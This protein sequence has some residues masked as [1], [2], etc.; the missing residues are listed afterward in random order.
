MQPYESWSPKKAFDENYHES[1]NMTF[2]LAIEAL[3]KGEYVAR[4]GWNGK[5]T[6]LFWHMGKIFKNAQGFQT[7]ALMLFA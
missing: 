6:F 2:S 3:K 5:G 7:G 1:S 4:K